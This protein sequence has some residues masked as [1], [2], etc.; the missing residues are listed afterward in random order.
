MGSNFY[1]YG[2]GPCRS[3]VKAREKK[4]REKLEAA[5]K[6][7]KIT[8]LVLPSAITTHEISDDDNNDIDDYSNDLINDDGH[9][10]HDVLSSLDI[11]RIT[12]VHG[13]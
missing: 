13:F 11:G 10:T 9:I 6:H 4:E 7:P 3:S 2:F 5:K 1:R 8:T 12:L